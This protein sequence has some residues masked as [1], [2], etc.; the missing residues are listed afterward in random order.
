MHLYH[1][2]IYFLSMRYVN[3]DRMG[4]K[5]QTEK[6][7]FLKILRYISPLSPPTQQNNRHKTTTAQI[8]KKKIYNFFKLWLI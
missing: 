4:Q 3:I 2:N 5:S 8:F 7:I 6:V 1:D